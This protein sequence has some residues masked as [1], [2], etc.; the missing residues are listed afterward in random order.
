MGVFPR[1]VCDTIR[2]FMRRGVVIKISSTQDIWKIAH[3]TA[4]A[5]L[6]IAKKGCLEARPRVQ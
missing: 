3:G 2:E 1:H 6:V 5:G 4:L